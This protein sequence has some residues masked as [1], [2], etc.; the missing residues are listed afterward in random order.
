MRSASGMDAIMSINIL[1]V[2]FQKKVKKIQTN[3]SER[4]R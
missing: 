3:G 4:N 1:Y 2:Y